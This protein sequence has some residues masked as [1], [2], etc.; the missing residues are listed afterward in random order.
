[1]SPLV[2][3]TLEAATKFANGLNVT[4]TGFGLGATWRCTTRGFR[5]WTTFAGRG[6]DVR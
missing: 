5:L 2:P 1:V 4:F 3:K 6:R